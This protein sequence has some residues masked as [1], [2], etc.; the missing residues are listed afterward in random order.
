MINVQNNIKNSSFNRSFGE[1]SPD[2]ENKEKKKYDHDTL[3]K[4]N[5]VTSARISY[6][7]LSNAATVYPTKGLT[8]NKNANF[9]EFLTMGAVPYIIGSATMM[10]VFN[11]A[12][13]YFQPFEKAKSSQL[14]NKM[15]LGVLFYGIGKELSK[16]LIT[17]PVKLATGIDVD[18]PY[19]KVI[20]ELPDYKNDTDIT[21][22]EYHKVF[23][24][25]EFPRWDLLYGDETKGEKR[26]GYYDKVA[27]KLG[28]GENL[29][30]S[31][32]EV[33]PMIKEIVTKTATVKNLVTY[34]WAGL[35]VAVA[36]QS[37]W[38]TFCANSKFKFYNYSMFVKNERTKDFNFGA[39]LGGT[40]QNLAE[41]AG[42]KV[43]NF[44]R[45]FYRSVKELY[46]GGKNAT[47]ANKLAGKLFIIAPIVATILGDIAIISN[48]KKPSKTS[49]GTVI[50]QDKRHLVN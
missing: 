45:A 38:E 19:A 27:K 40:I 33:K 26:N 17:K 7:K 31:D 46:C 25:V 39:K 36:M 6:D 20:Y 47:K 34:L 37:P 44:G 42:R 10:G 5:I 48:K 28:L 30:D 1:S 11:L 16:P 14:G 21:S 49:V 23:E 29:N 50:Q 22:I 4:N 9:Y 2:F 15:A 41:A 3:L 12:S 32:Q 8:G 35:G 24:S 18:I 13:K 43:K